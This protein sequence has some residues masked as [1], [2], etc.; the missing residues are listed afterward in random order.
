M[1]EPITLNDIQIPIYYTQ[2]DGVVLTSIPTLVPYHFLTK[3]DQKTKNIECGIASSPG[4][5][6]YF[7]F[8]DPAVNTFVEHEAKRWMDKDW[9]EF[10]GKRKIAVQPLSLVLRDYAL[11]THIDLLSVDAEGMGLEVLKSNDW[12]QWVPDVI[13][14]EDDVKDYLEGKGYI[15]YKECGLSNIYTHSRFQNPFLSR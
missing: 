11:N 12:T 10:L 1:W 13:V 7:S 2:K 3:H 4:E 6:T 14:V 9:L 5:L 8:S 15:L